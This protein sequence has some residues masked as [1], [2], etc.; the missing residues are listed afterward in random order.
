MTIFDFD[1]TLTD[2]DTLFGFYREVCKNERFFFLKKNL[3]LLFGVLYKL[4]FISNT[5]LKRVGVSL[6]LKNKYRHCLSEHAEVYKKSI[7]LNQVYYSQFLRIRKTERVIIS[8]SLVDYLVEI[9]PE[10]EVFGSRLRYVDEK[11]V[12]LKDNLYGEAKASLV[13]KLGWKVGTVYTDSFS[14]KPLMDLA[15]NVF[16]IKKG[17]IDQIK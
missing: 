5:T 4:N 1:K 7:Q 13:N 12:G 9:F 16:L 17:Q 14:D 6:F 11:V 2:Y 8:A 15:E 3:L 10:E